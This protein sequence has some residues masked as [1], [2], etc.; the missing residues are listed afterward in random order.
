M[1]GINGLYL[2]ARFVVCLFESVML[3]LSL[4]VRSVVTFFEKGVSAQGI[5]K[6]LEEENFVIT[7]QMSY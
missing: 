2:C 3:R 6:Y 5:H 1:Q 7:K 4:E